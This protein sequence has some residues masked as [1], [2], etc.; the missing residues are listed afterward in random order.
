[1]N[2]SPEYN[3]KG[4]DIDK[5]TLKR[6]LKTL[7]IFK[8]HI[9]LFTIYLTFLWHFTVNE[10]PTVIKELNNNILLNIDIFIYLLKKTEIIVLY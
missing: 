6:L 2:N 9:Y 4:I 8:W 7:Y 3:N 10:I 1:M 5:K